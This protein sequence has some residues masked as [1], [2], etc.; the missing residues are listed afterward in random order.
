MSSPENQVPQQPHYPPPYYQDDEITLKELILKIIEFWREIKKNLLWILVAG[1]IGAALFY[2]KSSMEETKYT[3][4]L[5]FMI[6]EEA[7]NKQVAVS[8]DLMG[9]GVVDYNLDKISALVKSSRIMQKALVRKVTVD[10]VNDYLGNHLIDIY[11]LNNEWVKESVDGKYAYLALGGFR[12]NESRWPNFNPR[13]R[14]ALSI[15]QD[16][17][18]GNSLK[19]KK[20]FLTVSYDDATEVFLL[21]AATLNAD[22]STVLLSA[23]YEELT[24]FYIE[25]T[26]G[27][28]SAAHLEASILVDSLYTQLTQAERSL[29]YAEDRTQ[30]LIG[31]GA[32][33]N[34]ADMSRKVQDIDSRYQ[35]A[36]KTKEALEAVLNRQ[37]PDFLLID[38]TFI[39]MADERSLL[40]QLIIGGFLFGFL[41]VVYILGRKI[42]RDAMA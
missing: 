13:E 11:E 3:A 33:L 23:V 37:T 1:A 32:R 5:S 36:L 4:T 15:L 39:P 10:G 21:K 26:V 2:L 38:R 41:A 29:A 19:K 9:I 17:S 18:V 28:P 12:F 7:D 35:Q 34:I 31:S 6:S 14:R 40:K 30:G 16:I 8:P 25:K 24:D 42:I 22:L 27:R 20:G